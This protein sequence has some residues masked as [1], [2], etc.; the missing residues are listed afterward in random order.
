MKPWEV[1]TEGWMRPQSVQCDLGCKRTVREFPY[2]A[3]L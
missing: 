2:H 3:W 1:C